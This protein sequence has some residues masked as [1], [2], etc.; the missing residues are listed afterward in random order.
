MTYSSQIPIIGFAAWSGTGKTTL[1]VELLQLFSA[2]NIRVGVIKHAHHTF[3]IDHEGKDSYRLRKAGARQ[4]LIGSEK[5]WALIVESDSKE[6][7]SLDDF[8][9]QLD[10]KNLDLI[11]VEGFKLETLPKIELIRPAL[12]KPP[13]YP[14]D[15]SVIAIATD[16]ELPVS[17]TLPVL[18]LNKPEQIAEFIIKCFINNNQNTL[19]KNAGA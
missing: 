13:F 9:Q 2:R 8:I 16:G 12:G 14:D 7:I 18:D 3:E 4:M 19:S 17:T 5:R 1:L 10:Q 6:K 11:L 15:N